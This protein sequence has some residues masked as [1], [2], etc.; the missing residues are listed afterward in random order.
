MAHALN[1][2][3]NASLRARWSTETSC[4]GS[5]DLRPMIGIVSV[6]VAARRPLMRVAVDIL[7]RPARSRRA[8]ALKLAPYVHG[9]ARK[10]A[11]AGSSRKSSGKGDV[12]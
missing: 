4:R 7:G 5:V 6:T 8:P 12:T 9:E 10:E 1:L 3:W 11:L 2:P